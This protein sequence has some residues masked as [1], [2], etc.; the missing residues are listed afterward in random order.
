MIAIRRVESDLQER[1]EAA[2]DDETLIAAVGRLRMALDEVDSEIYQVRIRS[3]QDPLNFPIK[4][5]NRLANLLSMSERGDG[6]PGSAMYV[7]LEIMVERLEGLLGELE[8]VGQGELGDEMEVTALRVAIGVCVG[9]PDVTLALREWSR[10]GESVGVPEGFTGPLAL[11]PM[12]CM[13]LR[14]LAPTPVSAGRYGHTNGH[15]V[16]PSTNRFGYH[17]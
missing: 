10:E 16:Q 4:V 7:V 2:A 5:N 1:L 15:S 17:E 14:T 6:R 9:T 3:N 11:D 8:A 13:G 12:S